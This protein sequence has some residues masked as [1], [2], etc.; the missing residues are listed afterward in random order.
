MNLCGFSLVCRHVLGVAKKQAPPNPLQGAMRRKNRH[1]AI[2]AIRMWLLGA[3]V[4]A[5]GGC[6]ILPGNQASSTYQLPASQLVASNA[7]RTDLTLRIARPVAD[8]RQGGTDILV[9]PEAFRLQRYGTGR[10]VA[11]MPVLVRDHLLEAFAN[12]ARFARVI[13]DR[14]DIPVDMEL[15]GHLRAYRVTLN[16]AAPRARV[17]FH[18]QVLDVQAHR[19]IQSKRFTV[20]EPMADAQVDTAVRALWRAT[21]QLARELVQWVGAAQ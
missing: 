15:Q 2:A 7:T 21:E 13:S 12:D 16:N 14:T 8:G 3:I 18:A 1:R 6:G 4:V 5:L 19:L 17:V 9:S 10:W 11:P 20:T